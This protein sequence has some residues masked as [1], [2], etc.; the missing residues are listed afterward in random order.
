MANHYVRIPQTNP[1]RYVPVGLTYSDEYE[2]RPYDQEWYYDLK[3]YF[4]RAVYYERKVQMSD[5]VCIHLH[6][7]AVCELTIINCDGRVVGGVIPVQATAV[8]PG[9]EK[10]GTQLTTYQWKFKPNEI[11]GLIEGSYYWLIKF[12]THITRMSITRISA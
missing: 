11:V 8:V 10:N 5:I 6:T 2:D 1:D 12:P 3:K 4:Q 9:N 7:N